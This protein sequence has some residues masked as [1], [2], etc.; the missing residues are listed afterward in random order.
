MRKI[1]IYGK[2]GIGKSTTAANVAAAMAEG[3]LK[4]AVVGC[5]PKADTTRCLVGRRIPTVLQQLGSS[6][7]NSEIAVMGYKGILCIESGGPEPGTGCAGRGIASAL[8]EIKERDLLA[9]RDVV[10]YDVLGDVVCGGF[11]M[12]LREGVADDV[13]LVTTSDFM[14]IYA[15]NN[16]CRGIAKYAQENEV[17][18]AGIIYNGRSGCSDPKRVKRFAEAIGTQVI[19]CVPMSG[20][21][22]QAE[23]ARKTVVEMA[24]DCE[25]ALAF[26]AIADKMIAGNPRCI[27]RPLLD[28]EVEQ[29]CGLQ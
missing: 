26:R 10:L 17:R 28:E 16:I 24:S 7:E 6:T 19:G 4:T 9:D 2:G 13:Y 27:P 3:G 25:A 15:A 20:Q 22:G 12:P 18:L 5:D 14:A 11:S 23:I 21:I 8:R 1:C 29:L